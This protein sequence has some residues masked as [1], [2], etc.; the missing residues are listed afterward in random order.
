MVLC[1]TPISPLFAA[2][3]SLCLVASSVLTFY[4]EELF[5]FATWRQVANDSNFK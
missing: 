3:P 1:Q 2:Q 5:D 4:R